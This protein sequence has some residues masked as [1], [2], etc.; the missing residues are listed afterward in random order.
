M[1]SGE[2][3]VDFSAFFTANATAQ[4]VTTTIAVATET[5][6]ALLNSGTVG[7]AEA[8]ADVVGLGEADVLEESDITETVLS[9]ALVTNISPLPGS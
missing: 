5:S 9:A 3:S 1:K 8:D 2:V 4:K 6:A 7:V